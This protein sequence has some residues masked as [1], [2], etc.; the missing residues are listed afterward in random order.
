MN[1]Q[2]I[3]TIGILV[4]AVLAIG[5]IGYAVR[6][7]VVNNIINVP[8]SAITEELGVMPGNSLESGYF[9][10]KGFCT[11]TERGF[12]NRATS[13]LFAIKNPWNSTST[14]EYFAF[15]NGSRAAF[16]TTTVATTTWSLFTGTSTN[17]SIGVANRNI[18]TTTSAFEG[19]ASIINGYTFA[20]SS[21]GVVV[22]GKDV[23]A[24][25]NSYSVGAGWTYTSRFDKWIIAGNEYVV[26]FATS[27]I[28][29]AP[30]GWD[31][32]G[33]GYILAFDE[34]EGWTG[35]PNTS[36][37]CMYEARFVKNQ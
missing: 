12:C 31:L 24:M 22:A 23:N 34:N 25:T 21:S 30:T 37:N 35:Q 33:S 10:N 29:Q 32:A 5:I 16:G 14:L 11:Y 4:V 26:G 3:F 36:G 20:T 19:T 2:S 6:K 7:P 27:S 8:E 9:C 15:T 13:T 1:K 28:K 18:A 17:A